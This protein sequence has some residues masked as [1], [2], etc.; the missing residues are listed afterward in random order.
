MLGTAGREGVY[1]WDLD[2]ERRMETIKV[3]SSIPDRIMVCIVFTPIPRG[4]YSFDLD[5]VS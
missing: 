3:E 4:L 2:D 5:S 1:L